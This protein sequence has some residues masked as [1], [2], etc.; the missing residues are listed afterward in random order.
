MQ[1]QHIVQLLSQS[2]SRRE[3]Q[4]V[5]HQSLLSPADAYCPADGMHVSPAWLSPARPY[6]ACI[7]SG[8]SYRTSNV[9]W[10]W[11]KDQ[12]LPILKHSCI[13]Q[14]QWQPCTS[15]F[16]SSSLLSEVPIRRLSTTLGGL[17][18]RASATSLQTHTTPLLQSVKYCS[19]RI[20]LHLCLADCLKLSTALDTGPC[21]CTEASC[22]CRR[23]LWR[24]R[25]CARSGQGR[26]F[27][28]S[29][30]GR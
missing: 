4:G 8:T 25:R 13:R 14:W 5:C 20:S 1:S 19:L 10:P 3:C 29:S 12:S 26:S 28:H 22:S 9:L 30:G 17:H 18:I 7:R 6:A 23:W 27:C 2:K 16:A 21:R 24:P 11:A 15:R